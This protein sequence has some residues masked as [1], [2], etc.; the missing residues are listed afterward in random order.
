MR[1]GTA[2]RPGLAA[3]SCGPW[4]QEAVSGW[5]PRSANAPVDEGRQDSATHSRSQGW[6]W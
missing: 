5:A 2:R 6:M 4:G 1:K 3:Q